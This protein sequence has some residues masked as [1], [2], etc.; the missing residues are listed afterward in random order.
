MQWSKGPSIIVNIFTYDII[1]IVRGGRGFK[2]VDNYHSFLR[3]E[4][5]LDNQTLASQPWVTLTNI[6]LLLNNVLAARCIN[7]TMPCVVFQHFL[8]S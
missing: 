6:V 5:D 8:L 2:N 4:N 1:P 3:P 7:L